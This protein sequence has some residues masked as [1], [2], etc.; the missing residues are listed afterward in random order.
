MTFAGSFVDEDLYTAVN[1]I[2]AERASTTA[3]FPLVFR[4]VYN[5]SS[6]DGFNSWVSVS[7]ADGGTANVTLTTVNDTT[8]GAPGCGAAAT[9]T[10]TYTITGSFIF[11]QNLDDPA[12]NGLNATPGCLWGGMTITSDNGIIAIANVGDRRPPVVTHQMNL[13]RAELVD[14]GDDVRRQGF[15]GVVGIWRL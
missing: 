11:F 7:V 9:Y 2:P 1:G 10:A 15:Q 13:F 4:R 14:P 5:T 8:T 3:K 12:V 6:L